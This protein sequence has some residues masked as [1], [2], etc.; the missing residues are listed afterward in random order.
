MDESDSMHIHSLRR[1]PIQTMKIDKGKVLE[2]LR[3]RGQHS[4]ADWVD[5]ELP[6]RIDTA[7]HSGILATLNLNPADFADP[8]S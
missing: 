1:E 2:A 6:D 4:R 3:H 5:R 7:Q 8:P